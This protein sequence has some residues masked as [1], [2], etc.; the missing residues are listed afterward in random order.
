M[1]KFLIIGLVNVFLTVV[2]QLFFGLSVFES[3]VFNVIF[4]IFLNFTYTKLRLLA[5]GY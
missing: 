4:T 2:G 1:K 5:A 3:I